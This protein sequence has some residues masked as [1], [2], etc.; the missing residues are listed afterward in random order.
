MRSATVFLLAALAGMA[1]A[2]TGEVKPPM[3]GYTVE[4][5]AWEFDIE[6]G[7]PPVVLK[8]TA[9]S[10]MDQLTA[11]YPDFA[12][13]ALARIAS[14]NVDSVGQSS[15][16]P[17]G[18]TKR[19]SNLCWVFPIA[20]ENYIRDGI[21]Y[22]HGVPGRPSIPA[23]PRVCHRVSCSWGS[24]IWWCNDNNF[25]K[26]LGSYKD[27]ANGAQACNNECR[28]FAFD[29]GLDTGWW[30]SGQ[31]FHNDGINIIIRGGEANC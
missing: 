22:L 24:G 11:D 6:E 23:G 28:R 15:A 31:R 18:L 25:S 10:V 12:S 3:E 14:V 29:A 17:E 8:G 26:T 20:R 5:P 9:E 4:E 2:A 16:V 27:I 7:K 30:T 13:K 21:V 1:T 19:D